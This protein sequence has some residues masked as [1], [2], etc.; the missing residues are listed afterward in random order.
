MMKGS[1]ARLAGR[2]RR[3]SPVT[4]SAVIVGVALL[5]GVL[6]YFKPDIQTALR[7]GE[8]I[9]VEFA[10]DYR[11]FVNET[12]V[13]L[14][15]LR[16]GVL[17]DKRFTEDGTMVATIKVD[18]GVRDKLGPQPSASIEPLTVLGGRY[19][20]ELKHGGGPGRFEGESIP[21]ER[22]RIPVELDRILEALPKP[23]RKSLQGVVG[24]F[25]D[26]LGAGVQE[27]LPDLLDGAPPVL[28]SGGVV[29]DALRG[30]RPDGDLSDLVVHLE[31]T[32]R[33]LTRHDGQLGQIVDSLATTTSTLAKRSRPLADTLDTLP[34]TLRDTR[35][36]LSALGATLDK[37]TV[38]AGTFRPSVR[39]LDPLLTRLDPALIKAAPLMRDLR[40]LLADARPVVERLV[41][42][43]RRATT[44]LDDVR[45]PVLDRVNGPIAHTVLNTWRGTGPYAGNGGGFQAG[46]KFYEEL[47]HLVT[48]LDNASKTQ[49]A[50]GSLLS[51]QVGAGTSS[52]AGVPLDFQG[53]LKHLTQ[54]AGG[55]R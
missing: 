8:E 12:P 23:T 30:T 45:G 55:A 7:A 38:A 16:V 5:V 13:K 6:L 22:T 53:L 11:L 41:P 37:A 49:D 4:S 47:G 50:Q 36:G 26:T 10:R 42:T 39:E 18:E 15:G 35:A 25:D 46:N 19:A 2:T 31:A 48:N 27:A 40:P 9:D 3:L 28:K 14:G 20:V 21:R 51:F 52:V 34:E 33:V 32:A 44:V 17:E 1:F 29:V 24:K 43:A 54:L